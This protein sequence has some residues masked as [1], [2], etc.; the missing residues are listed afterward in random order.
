MFQTSAI[1]FVIFSWSSH[2]RESKW[3][4][5]PTAVGLGSLFWWMFLWMAQYGSYREKRDLAKFC[6]HLFLVKKQLEW[7]QLAC[8][9]SKNGDLKIN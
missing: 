4:I 9:P 7:N 1:R 3:A 8:F 2:R 5:S 6:S